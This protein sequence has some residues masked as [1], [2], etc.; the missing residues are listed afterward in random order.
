[1]PTLI[2]KVS[3]SKDSL[4]VPV[5]STETQKCSTIFY[6]LVSQLFA[7]RITL[8]PRCAGHFVRKDTVRALLKLKKIT[9]SGFPLGNFVIKGNYIH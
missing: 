8:L 6:N 4:K 5:V 2:S 7:H 1:M 9:S 3:L